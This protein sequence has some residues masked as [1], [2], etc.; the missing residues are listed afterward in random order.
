LGGGGAGGAMGV[1][2][3]MMDLG[4]FP[5]YVERCQHL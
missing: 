5:F 3:M 2:P 1:G 4:Q